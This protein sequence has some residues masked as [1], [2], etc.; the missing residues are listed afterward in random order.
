MARTVI[1]H[2]ALDK[3]EIEPSM[4][5]DILI[6]K[7]EEYANY[8]FAH[9]HEQLENNPNCYFKGSAFLNEILPFATKEKSIAMTEEAESLD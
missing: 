2:L 7:M 8:G 4:V 6:D 3:G 1:N 5:V 9:M